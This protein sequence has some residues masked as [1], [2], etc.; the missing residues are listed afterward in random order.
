MVKFRE[1]LF[2]QNDNDKRLFDKTSRVRCLA[3]TS[4]MNQ[5]IPEGKKFNFD[6][7]EKEGGCYI[8]NDKGFHHFV[9]ECD[10]REVEECPDCEA[11]EK[12]DRYVEGDTSTFLVFEC[13]RSIEYLGLDDEGEVST[14]CPRSKKKS[15]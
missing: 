15:K 3:T 14:E 4:L 8:K 9:S 2:K 7:Y 11:E 13:G 5:P 12:E 1:D 10:L 6:S